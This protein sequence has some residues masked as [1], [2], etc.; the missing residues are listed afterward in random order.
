VQGAHQPGGQRLAQR[1]RHDQLF[2]LGHQRFGGPSEQVGVDAVLGSGEFFLVE[3]G[4]DGLAEVGPGH[5]GQGR[6]A[7]EAERL[8]QGRGGRGRVGAQLGPARGGQLLEPDDVGVA[9]VEREPVAGRPGL[10]HR[11]GQ[12][13]AQPGDQGLQRVRGAGRGLVGPQAVDEL[14]GRHDLAGAKRQHDQQRAQPGPADLEHLSRAGADLQRSEHRDLHAL[15]S[16]WA[17]VGVRR[18]SC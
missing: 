14:A 9:R 5:L 18:G 12:R 6:A 7:P 2:Q 11:L 10:D 15:N 1:M 17:W 4:G 16:A 3:P 8:A 13:P